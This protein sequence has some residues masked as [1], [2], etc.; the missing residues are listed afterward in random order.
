[1][2]KLGD[3]TPP[4]SSASL[5]D[6]GYSCNTHAPVWA[7]GPAPVPEFEV[8]W[9]L[10]NE[11]IPSLLPTA[12]DSILSLVAGGTETR[13][14]RWP[15]S[16]RSVP[17]QRGGRGVSTHRRLTP[18]PVRRRCHTSFPGCCASPPKRAGRHGASGRCFEHSACV[19]SHSRPIDPLL[20]EASARGELAVARVRLGTAAALLV[21]P[22]SALVESRQ[23]EN[24]IGLGGALAA[25]LLSVVVDTLVTR[26]LSPLVQ[27]G[28]Q[29]RGRL[30]RERHAGRLPRPRPPAYCGEQQSR[31]RVLLP[32]AG[33]GHPPLRRSDLSLRRPARPSSTKSQQDTHRQCGAP[34]ARRPYSISA[35]LAKATASSSSGARSCATGNSPQ[36]AG[37]GVGCCLRGEAK[38]G[39]L[40]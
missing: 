37:A 25:V 2:E 11:G 6:M 24:L 3:T 34:R 39:I 21:I 18:G 10:K 27:C 5:R 36:P 35:P 32:A 38:T 26:G 16:H 17:I 28:H 22:V 12:L 19:G 40:G 30:D 1:M 33:R 9:P 13:S 14:L 23:T 29:R 8:L 31:L 7:R 20:V 4:S 15:P